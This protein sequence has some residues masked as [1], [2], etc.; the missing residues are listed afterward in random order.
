MKKIALFFTLMCL[1]F[2]LFGQSNGPIIVPP[3]I[4]DIPIY[5]LDT[6]KYLFEEIPIWRL[7]VRLT[8]ADVKN[9]GTDSTVYVEMNGKRFYMDSGYNDFQRNDHDEE[10]TLFDIV[11]P[12]A[13]VYQL[14]DIKYLKFGVIG[15]DGWCAKQIEIRVNALNTPIFK[16]TFSSC[17]WVDGDGQRS[18]YTFSKATLRNNYYWKH[19]YSH[20]NN[21]FYSLIFPPNIIPD[22]VISSMIEGGLGHYKNHYN[23]HD[24]SIKKFSQA[25]VEFIEAW[26]YNS[27]TSHYR[28]DTDWYYRPGHA[29][30]DVDFS[31][32]FW[33][34]SSENKFHVSVFDVDGSA[35]VTDHWPFSSIINSL[36]GS[37][38]DKQIHESIKK[39][40]AKWSW[41]IPVCPDFDLDNEGNLH[42]NGIDR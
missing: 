22:N 21:Y 5:V 18:S 12:I 8:T 4:L 33:C 23:R 2:P 31:V 13:G 9:A 14:K 11:A 38:I 35:R 27:G 15:N 16:H 7:Q 1:F 20:V 24:L 26:T 6:N 10:H 40:N 17:M 36:F 28:V 34:N 30:I 42:I 41:D 19:V 3:P 32:N 39:F 25:S 29:N 37:I